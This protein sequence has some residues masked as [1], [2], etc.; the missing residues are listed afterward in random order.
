MDGSLARTPLTEVVRRICHRSDSVVLRLEGETGRRRIY[1]RD[2]EV[3]FASSDLPEDRLGQRLVEAGAVSREQ[4]D[5]ACRVQEASKLRLGATLVEMGCLAPEDLEE[6]LREQVAAI[7]LASLGCRT[8]SFT[9]APPSRERLESDLERADLSTMDLLLDGIRAHADAATIRAGIEDLDNRPI[10][11]ATNATAAFDAGLQLTPEE[12]F[13]L[14]RV[15]GVSTASQIARVSPLG[16]DETYRCIYSL[17]TSGL[18]EIEAAPTPTE[19]MSRTEAASASAPEPRPEA[20]VWERSNREPEPAEEAP[21]FQTVRP[22]AVA[23]ASPPEPSPEVL[24]FRDRMLEKY[25]HLGTL[26]HYELLDVPVSSQPS[27]I[28]SAYFRLAKKL[29]PDHRASLKLED[30]DGALATLY[31]EITKAYE[32]LSSETGRRAYDFSLRK[33]AP[34]KDEEPTARAGYDPS[35]QARIHFGNGLRFFESGHFHE[36]IE[37]LR[38]AVRLDDRRADYH[39]MLGRALGKNPKWRKLAEEHLMRALTLNRFD[40]ATYV[41]LGEL[42]H[43]SGLKTRARKMYEDAIGIDPDNVPAREG[44]HSVRD[45]SG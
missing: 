23:F 22:V 30:R 5:L 19:T 31:L 34:A 29:H 10:R 36:A 9:T 15:D 20:V 26:T 44:L 40:A 12:G 32:V 4:L 16:E 33:S 18:L 24:E 2:G 3:V 25:G 17:V 8:G 27:E 45:L 13:V 1:F 35:Q 43:G 41:A 39:R 42:Y 14:S 38:S 6:R 11:V 37:E 7:V 28:K 21:N